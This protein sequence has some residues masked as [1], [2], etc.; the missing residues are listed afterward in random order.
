MADGWT[1]WTKWTGWTEPK[2]RCPG[3]SI[4]HRVHAVHCVHS[5]GRG[6]TAI[7]VTSYPS[8]A[9]SRRWDACATRGSLSWTAEHQLGGWDGKLPS[10]GSVVPGTL[11][12]A[13]VSVRVPNFHLAHSS[14]SVRQQGR[15]RRGAVP[16]SV[17]HSRGVRG[18]ES[19]RRGAGLAPS[20]SPTGRQQR[21]TARP[22][23]SA[24]PARALRRP[25]RSGG[26]RGW[27]RLGSDC[28]I[29]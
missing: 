7:G 3:P 8:W 1:W 21:P 23:Q 4:V 17:T 9:N 10:R 11:R 2:P 6:Q 19:P 12:R 13:M 16:R 28:A 18:D 22:E 15:S 20:P 27:R 14:A 29:R 24:R 26:P 25:G 5:P